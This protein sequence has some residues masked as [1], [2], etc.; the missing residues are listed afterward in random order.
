ME[1]IKL[2]NMAEFKIIWIAIVYKSYPINTFCIDGG[3][4]L[5]SVNYRPFIS[6]FILI[7]YPKNK[8]F[9][10]FLPLNIDS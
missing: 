1:Q 9:T 5:Q 8:L 6:N 10:N 4:D 3:S 7:H 2:P